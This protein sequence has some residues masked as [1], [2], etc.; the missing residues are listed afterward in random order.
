M[1]VIIFYSFQN[2]GRLKLQKSGAVFKATKTGKLDHINK[3]DIESAQWLRVA[4]G[5][6][7]KIVLKSG[8]QFR[9]EG[10]RESVSVLSYSFKVQDTVHMEI[11]TSKL[12]FSA[13][14]VL[15]G[16]Y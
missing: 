14:R 9:F 8:A 1:T 3:E 15:A 16:Q 2:A 7:L 12:K 13:R 4:R 5:Q 10:F 6:E 11:V